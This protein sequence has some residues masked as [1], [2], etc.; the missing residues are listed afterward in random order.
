MMEEQILPANLGIEAAFLKSDGHPGMEGGFL[1]AGAIDA[2]QRDHFG[3]GQRAFDLVD[4][5]GLEPQPLDEERAEFHRH[6]VG[7]FQPDHVAEPALIHQILDC[8]EQ[9]IGLVLLDFHIRIAGDAE[10]SGS[11]HL[12]TGEQ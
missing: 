8:L 12:M 6:A 4:L 7:K 9:I 10:Q 2:V 1:Q 11:E 3:K 5:K